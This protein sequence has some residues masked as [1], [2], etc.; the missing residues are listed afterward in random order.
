MFCAKG[1]HP[2][3]FKETSKSPLEWLKKKYVDTTYNDWPLQ[4]YPHETDNY[5]LM[6]NPYILI[7]S[8]RRNLVINAI[9]IGLFNL[10]AATDIEQVMDTIMHNFDLPLC[11]VALPPNFT[12]LYC[13]SSESTTIRAHVLARALTD[14]DKWKLET[15]RLK[16]VRCK[17][18]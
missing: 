3:T 11:S 16:Y 1:Y 17:R 7:R 13:K 10:T 5:M 12:T 8:G 14:F 9:E 4:L 2:D 6:S 18:T 15:R